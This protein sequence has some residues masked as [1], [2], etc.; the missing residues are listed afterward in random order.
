LQPKE[1]AFYTVE[2]TEYKQSLKVGQT[3]FYEAHFM[4]NSNEM[5]IRR[6]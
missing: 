6:E 4:L 1:K 2:P 5:L 3:A